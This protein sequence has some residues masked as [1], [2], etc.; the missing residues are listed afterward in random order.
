MELQ[1][2]L[3]IESVVPFGGDEIDIAQIG[4]SLRGK[5]ED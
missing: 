4:H 1:D 5:L 2:V 3:G